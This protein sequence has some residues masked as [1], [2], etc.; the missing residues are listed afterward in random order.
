MSE[1]LSVKVDQDVCMGMG[2]CFRTAPT[3]FAP[4]D[5]GIVS[6]L[7]G[8]TAT[9]P[10]DLPAERRAA[11]VKAS[12]LCPSGAISLEGGDLS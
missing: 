9:G 1:G 8:D 5:D 4:D 6:L 11:A 3:L 10:Q 12:Q 7:G 2:Y